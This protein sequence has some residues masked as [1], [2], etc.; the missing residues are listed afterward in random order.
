M[1]H[2]TIDDFVKAAKKATREA[3]EAKASRAHRQQST[4]E[5][6]KTNR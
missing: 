2:P 3:S 4:S 6:T 5:K 1:T